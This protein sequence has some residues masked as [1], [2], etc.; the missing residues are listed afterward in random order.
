MASF[1]GSKYLNTEISTLHLSLD[2]K[3]VF[4]SLEFGQRIDQAR[5]RCLPFYVIAHVIAGKN[6]REM[7]YDGIYF[8]KYKDR[9]AL[10]NVLEVHYLAIELINEKQ[11][12]SSKYTVKKFLSGFSSEVISKGI[13]VLSYGGFEE[14]ESKSAE[15]ESDRKTR[16]ELS[17]REIDFSQKYLKDNAAESIKWYRAAALQGNSYA[18]FCIGNCHY[19]GIN[20]LEQNFDLAFVFY[21]LAADQNYIEALEA[22]AM[23]HFYGRGV[24]KDVMA[25]FNLWKRAALAG[26]VE[27][28]YQLGMCCL[29]RDGCKR[30]AVEAAKWFSVAAEKGDPDAQ[31]EAAV[32]HLTG[33][34]VEQNFE[35]AFGLLKAAADQGRTNAEYEVGLSYLWGEGIKEDK[36]EAVKYLQRAALKGQA[37]A[38]HELG[39]I[40]LNGEGPEPLEAFNYFEAAAAKGHTI[41]KK[42]VRWR[43]Q[44]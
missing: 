18:Q 36:S 42:M 3:D 2:Q 24:K 5:R 14:Q 33:E 7:N 10:E 38:L 30:D 13:D 40:G 9:L 28:Q 15:E 21:K 4:T 11:G 32:L 16:Q 25:A 41:A 17:Q 31:Y 12:G 37:D 22:Q 26:N 23:C 27:A 39:V 19:A 43:D 20:T 35:R 34:G 44:S 1:I 6:V 29:G 8:H